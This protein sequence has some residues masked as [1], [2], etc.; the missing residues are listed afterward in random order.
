MKIKALLIVLLLSLLAV[1]VGVAGPA[2]VLR[3]EAVL[4]IEELSVIKPLSTDSIWQATYGIV[5]KWDTDGDGDKERVARKRLWVRAE[6]LDAEGIVRIIGAASPEVS[7]DQKFHW[8][9]L[10]QNIR[11]TGWGYLWRK[12]S[13]SKLWCDYPNCADNTYELS[14]K[15]YG[16]FPGYFECW[17][18]QSP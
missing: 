12:W 18:W 14:C 13:Q 7:W 2:E 1:D 16:N 9:R 4:V 15:V 5:F 11:N 6:W 17:N 10:F 8:Q 3:P